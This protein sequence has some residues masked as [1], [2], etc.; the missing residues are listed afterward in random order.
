MLN[1]KVQF[2]RNVLFILDGLLLSAIWAGA[3]ELRWSTGWFDMNFDVPLRAQYLQGLW[4]VAPLWFF[5]I[6]AFELTRTRRQESRLGEALRMSR[7]VGLFTLVLVSASWLVFKANY[8]RIFLGAFFCTSTVSLLAQ[9]VVF[10]EFIRHLRRRGLNARS[11]LIVGTDGLARSIKAK[12]FRHPEL[13]VELAGYISV[14]SEPVPDELGGIPVLGGVGDLATILATRPVDEVFIAQ[15]R[16]VEAQLDLIL[17][18]VGEEL[19]NIN[20]VS[21]LYKHSML[22]GCVEDFEGMP[23]LA[24]NTSPMAGWG[25]V[26]KR[27]FDFVL[28]TLGLIFTLPLIGLGALLV[29]LTSP[30]PAFYRQ[31]RFGLDGRR[32]W[33]HKIRT[34]VHDAE[35]DG[36]VWGITDDPRVTKVGRILRMVSID[37]LPQLWNVIRGDMS[38]VGPRPAQPVFVQRF[39][40]SIPKYMLRHRVKPGLTGWAQVNGQRGMSPADERLAFDLYYIRN[41]SVALDCRIIWRTVWGGFLNRTG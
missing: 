20:L 24:V 27:T 7:A 39:K 2:W 3:Y 25:L 21:D 34:M 17:N 23:I 29:K 11:A 12:L 35:K 13:G 10:R 19:V 5:F 32:F 41:W 40:E 37:E 15:S 14:G 36:P 38:L 31:E 9:R 6:T 28:A 4:L 22:G 30:G 1:K 18:E 26:L 8:S 33:I 16:E